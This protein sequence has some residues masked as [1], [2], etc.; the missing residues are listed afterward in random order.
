MEKF[1]K[2][3]EKHKEKGFYIMI[4]LLCFAIY[5]PIMENDTYWIINLGK[6]IVNNGFPL[7]DPFTIHQ[8]LNI[9]IQQWLSD[10]IFYGA[11][12]FFGHSGIFYIMFLILFF[13]SVIL[14]RIC[15]KV[16]NNQI[17]S[18]II[19]SVTCI[20]INLLL[21]SRPQIFSQ[22]IF[23]L[24]ILTLEKYILY[25]KRK[26]LIYLILLSVLLINIHA[27]MWPVFFILFGPYI[28][29]GI[30]TKRITQGYGYLKL[31]ITFIISLCVGV[32]NPYGIKNMLYF[33]KSYGIDSINKTIQEMASP[34][35]KTAFGLIIFIL[36]MVFV[37]I[38]KGKGKSTLRHTLLATG[39]LYMGLS[40]VRS[41]F[42][43]FICMAL[44]MANYMKNND[45][46]DTL[47]VDVRKRIINYTAILLIIISAIFLKQIHPPKASAS[48]EPGDAVNYI[49]QNVDTNN[50][51][52]FNDFES[53]GYIEYNGL[54]AFIDSR[55]EIFVKKF[56]RKED[57]FDDYIKYM[58]GMLYYKDLVK[59]YGITHFLIKKDY[60]IS[61]YIMN[62]KEYTT[63]Y[64]DD[65]Y[66]LIK[67]NND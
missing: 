27:A 59:K 49:K 20:F 48:Y 5:Q 16:S 47:F 6:Y 4:F 54:K 42:L 65:I 21:K 67:V 19:V 9:T 10:V 18:M 30:K 40:S 52:L 22:L 1:I 44:F 32:F 37:G 28:L 23:L 55:C 58:S 14:Y 53:G 7:I 17:L 60:K 51:R 2:L 3:E 62:D 61:T 41:M 57:I 31:S 26:Y 46:L 12:Y 45:K 38:I 29:D 39:T 33:T 25:Q 24:E 11:D 63:I 36:M 13:N 35:F 64:S 56:N 34:D 8:G 43:F 50:M 15:M 66:I